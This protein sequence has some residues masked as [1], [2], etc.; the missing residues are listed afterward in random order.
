M[1]APRER[2]MLIGCGG[3]S[4]DGGANQQYSFDFMGHAC[5]IHRLIVVI[6]V[7]FDAGR[8]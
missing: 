7:L 3:H 5:D 6:A 2:G 4:A 1:F 8:F